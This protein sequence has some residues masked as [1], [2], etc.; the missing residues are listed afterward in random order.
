[1][2]EG[3]KYFLHTARHVNTSSFFC[4]KHYFTINYAVNIRKSFCEINLTWFSAKIP[5]GEISVLRKFRSAKFPFGEN[6]VRG[7]FLRRKFHRRKFLRQKFRTRH[8]VSKDDSM[9]IFVVK[10]LDVQTWFFYICVKNV[11]F[12][13]G[14]GRANKGS[15]VD[16]NQDENSISISISTKKYRQ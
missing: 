15:V 16:V 5:F 14:K 4:W 13:A 10:S 2:T 3:H 7:K 11:N 9:S 8:R 12:K 1:M 6:S